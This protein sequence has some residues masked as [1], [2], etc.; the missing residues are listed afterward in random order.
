MR[1]APHTSFCGTVTTRMPAFFGLIVIRATPFRLV[2]PFFRTPAPLT[3]T[4]A[5]FTGLPPFVTLTTTVFVLPSALSPFGVTVNVSQTT[6]F[7]FGLGLGVGGVSGVGT[8]VVAVA[9]LS[10][11]SDSGSWPTT[12]TVFVIVPDCVAVTI[13]VIVTVAP[14]ATTPRL[15]WIRP[16]LFAH[17]P[18]VVATETKLVPAGSASAAVTCV[19]ASGPLLPTTIV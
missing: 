19:A 6:G 18:C 7:G 4:V 14:L 13:N 1:L 17:V 8:S 12:V 10:D 11:V 2:L 3:T 5:P 16:P 9:V 15:H